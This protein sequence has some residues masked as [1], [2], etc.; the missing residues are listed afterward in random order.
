MRTEHIDLQHLQMVFRLEVAFTPEPVFH[1]R[2]QKFDGNSVANLEQPVG[3]RKRGVE[4]STVSEVTHGKVI[5]PMERT[6]V[7]CARG[8]D[9][10]YRKLSC[11]HV[12]TPV[13]S[14]TAV[15]RPSYCFVSAAIFASL[16]CVS[17]RKRLKS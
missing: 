1:G 6:Q 4:N 17:T 2:L 15:A 7:S 16:A 8:I 10:R 14:L 9:S 12:T 13:N 5:D 3:D 11:V